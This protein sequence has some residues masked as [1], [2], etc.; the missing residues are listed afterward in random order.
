MHSN[1]V[2]EESSTDTEE[3][4]MLNDGKMDD[5]VHWELMLNA[6]D[7]IEWMKIS[8]CG[9]YASMLKA[10]WEEDQMDGKTLRLLTVDDLVCIES[11]TFVIN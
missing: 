10:Q 6:D 5:K 1:A 11:V 9:K 3:Q 4:G 2:D 7:C 8:G